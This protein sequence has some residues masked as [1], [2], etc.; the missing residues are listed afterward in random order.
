MQFHRVQGGCRAPQ[1]HLLCLRFCTDCSISSL[2]AWLQDVASTSGT[3]ELT[4]CSLSRSPTVAVLFMQLLRTTPAWEGCGGGA[5]SLVQCVHETRWDATPARA[6]S[7]MFSHRLQWA[8]QSCSARRCSMLYTLVSLS[9]ASLAWTL[10]RGGQQ[11]RPE[12]STR[13][14]R[15]P[16]CLGTGPARTS[17]PASSSAARAAARPAPQTR[18][19][20]AASSC[21]RRCGRWGS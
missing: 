13:A 7:G 21:R 18:E 19:S 6:P 16:S 12:H 9:V 4:P 2:L 17:S 10:R 20:C 8:I 3:W 5:S 11:Q 14:R 15:A 1:T